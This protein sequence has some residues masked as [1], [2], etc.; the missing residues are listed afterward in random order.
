MFKFCEMYIFDDF[1]LIEIIRVFYKFVVVVVYIGNKFFFG[2]Y[3][4]YM[5]WNGLWYNVDDVYVKECIL[6]EVIN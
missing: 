4:C 6:F 5:K 2:Y 3:V 1:G